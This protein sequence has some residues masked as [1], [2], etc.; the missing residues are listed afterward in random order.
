VTDNGTWR[1]PLDDHLRDAYLRRLGFTTPPPVSLDTLFALTRAQVER[2]PYECVWVWL[3]ERRTIQ[4]ADSVRYLTSG[5]GGYCYH[6]NGSLSALLAWLGFAVHWHVGGV[7]GTPDA[8]VGATG[9][10]LV[11]HVANLPTGTNPEGR[12]LVDTGLGD[13]PHEPMPLIADTYRQGP[14]TYRLRPSDAVPGG[15][16]FDADPRMSLVGMDFAP[17]EATPSGFAVKHKFLSSSP[18]SGF[19]KI[20]TAFRRDANGVDHLRGC[21]LRRIAD[22]ITESVVDTQADWFQALA[23][24]FRLPLSDVDTER[25]NALWHKVITAHEAWLAKAQ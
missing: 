3:G 17:D 9:N 11:L 19:M 5:R 1:P 24:I 8:E 25:R 22:G 7:Q 4:A 20:L 18:E 12:W 14:F 21:V 23:D 15:W 13:G 16:R 2:V 6:M 10:H